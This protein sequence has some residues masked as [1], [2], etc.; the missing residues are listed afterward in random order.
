MMNLFDTTY[1]FGGM[2]QDKRKIRR[3]NQMMFELSKAITK[4]QKRDII[5][6]ANPT[7]YIFGIKLDPHNPYEVNENE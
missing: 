7:H 4:Q 6:R 5:K 1:L 2:C 3:M